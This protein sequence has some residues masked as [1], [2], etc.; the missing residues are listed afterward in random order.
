MKDKVLGLSPL[1]LGIWSRIQLYKENSEYEIPLLIEID[2]KISANKIEQA[3]NNVIEYNAAL[4]TEIIG[5]IHPIQKVHE[6][7]SLIL[8]KKAVLDADL[9]KEIETFFKEPVA[10]N[11]ILTNYRLFIGETCQV[12][13][14]KFHHII[15]DGHSVALFEKEFNSLLA[16]ESLTKDKELYHFFLN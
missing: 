8:V 4:R 15:A 16:G 7:D 14:C 10:L 12:L 5:E 11:G 6:F 9:R 2:S 1:Q 3:L 13:A